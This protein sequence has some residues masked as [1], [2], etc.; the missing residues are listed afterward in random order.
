MHHLRI[1]IPFGRES[2][3]LSFEPHEAKGLNKFELVREDLL[4]V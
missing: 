3:L 4:N 2:A 1:G